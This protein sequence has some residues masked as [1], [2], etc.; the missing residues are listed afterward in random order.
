MLANSQIWS[1]DF[2]SINGYPPG[3]PLSHLDFVTYLIVWKVNKQSNN[4]ALIM[5]EPA[6][7]YYLCLLAC[8]EAG[9]ITV[10]QV[11]G[12]PIE[13]VGIEVSQDASGWVTMWGKTRYG[14]CKLHEDPKR[15]LVMRLAIW[16]AGMMAGEFLGFGEKSTSKVSSITTTEKPMDFVKRDLEMIRED[17]ANVEALGLNGKDVLDA[18]SQLSKKIIEQR[19]PQIKALAGRFIEGVLA[20]D[21]SFTMDRQLIGLILQ[22]TAKLSMTGNDKES[23]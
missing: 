22:E 12:V 3:R 5:D 14:S 17:L 21:G 7:R 10:A 6:D 15:A 9:H 1:G 23:A 4:P 2:A 13:S 11:L 8:H 20:S 18:A 19:G 16:L